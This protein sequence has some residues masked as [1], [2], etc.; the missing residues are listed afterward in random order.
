MPIHCKWR[1]KSPFALQIS[2]FLHGVITVPRPLSH[3]LSIAGVTD[4]HRFDLAIEANLYDVLCRLATVAPTVRTLAPQVGGAS[5]FFSPLVVIASAAHVF[6]AQRPV[7]VASQRYITVL[8]PLSMDVQAARAVL[9][10]PSFV[11]V[12]G[13]TKTFC[14]SWRLITVA[15]HASDFCAPVC[16]RAH[17]AGS[18]QKVVAVVA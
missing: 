9:A 7:V 11:V 12:A 18:T 5:V 3:F 2:L 13:A 10:I 14:K 8:A 4:R 6:G 15:A 1:C 16:F 17:L